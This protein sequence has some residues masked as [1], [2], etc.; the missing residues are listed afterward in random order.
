MTTDTTHLKILICDDSVT[1]ILILTKLLESEGYFYH[2]SLTDPTRVLSAMQENSY[3]LLLLDIEMPKMNGFEVLQQINESSISKQLVPILV[4]TGRQGSEIRNKA[5]QLGAQDFVNKPFDQTEVILRVKNLLRVRASYLA[6]QNIAK[7]L[8]RKVKERTSEL[9]E[10]T[11]TLISILAQVGEMRDNDTG[12]HVI[13]VGKYARILSE[14]LEL[15]ADICYLI[16]KAAPLHDI[17]KI[18]IP[19]HILLKAG[20]LTDAEW[21]KM[22]KHAQ[23][24]ADLL[25]NHES[26]MV[27]LAA[28]I[29]LSHH[30]HWDG[31]GYPKQLKAAS[32]PIEG[33]ITAI[34]DVF[35]A[36]TT[37]RPYK[38]AWSIEK[39]VEYIKSK[40]GVQFDPQLVDLFIEN[41]DRIIAIREQYK[42]VEEC[43]TSQCI[44]PRLLTVV[45]ML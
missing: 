17:G 31:N 10:A 39:A 16:E 34:S 19:D 29:A 6:Q 9:N 40:A 2:T 26:L 11:D 32:I 45:G 4:L 30:E 44:P 42:D 23:M 43:Q 18:G 5:L 36:L 3:D 28:S 24:G 12:K 7:E 13:R 35:D 41:I 21:E 37:P 38:E 1:N 22:R 15:P 14:A 25:T 33:R 27:Q 20:K 8:E